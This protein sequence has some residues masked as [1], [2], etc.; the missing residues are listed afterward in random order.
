MA[1]R[2]RR[3]AGRD[4]VVVGRRRKVCACVC[5]MESFWPEKFFYS[6]CVLVQRAAEKFLLYFP[7]TGRA[8]L[9]FTRRRSS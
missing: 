4:I 7:I 8:E 1:M 5:A 2:K 9:D 3:S 6:V